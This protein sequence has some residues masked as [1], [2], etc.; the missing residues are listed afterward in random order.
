MLLLA[1]NINK[2]ISQFIH[3]TRCLSITEPVKD[4]SIAAV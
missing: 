4:Q 2:L 3:K 1:S